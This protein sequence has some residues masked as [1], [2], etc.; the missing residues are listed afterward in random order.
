M[1]AGLL[2]RAYR[3]FILSSH[4]LF[5][6]GV[7][8]LLTSESGFEVV[9]VEGEFDAAVERIYA[10][11]PDVVLIDGDR[12]SQAALI[13]QLPPDHRGLKVVS[14]TLND[15]TLGIYFQQRRVARGVD[16][17][18]DVLRGPI[19]KPSVED[20]STMHLLAVV[21]GKYGQRKV[22]NIQT[23]GPQGWTLNVWNAPTDLP[24]VVD[25]PRIFLPEE[26]PRSDL[27]LS[28]GES[29]GVVSLIPDIAQRTRAKSVIVPV[30]NVGWV[31]RGLANQLRAWL[32]D[33]GVTSAFPKPFCSL[34]ESSYGLKRLQTN[35]RNPFIAEFARHF[36]K[37]CFRFQYDDSRIAS[38][39]VVR[40]SAC[41]CARYVAQNL[42]GL[43]IDQAKPRAEALHD[44]YPCLADTDPDEDY[45]H[46]LRRVSSDLIK[47]AV[48]A[49]IL[50]RR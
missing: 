26:L 3:I 1:A 16:D 30:D 45:H 19:D 18:I 13:A 2:M 24:A 21:Q 20:Q 32:A 33:L 8:K 25:D 37:P 5:A 47:E 7:E 46:P 34:T 44:E 49:E 6:R 40:D 14:L 41:G 27:V 15:N 10:L 4:P 12:S 42:A 9:G 43:P 39:Q 11:Q 38:A 36:G 17:L 50:A 35:Y 29:P 31:P 28:F 48:G 23:N 22:R